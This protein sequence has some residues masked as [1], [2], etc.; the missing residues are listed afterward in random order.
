[1]T[2]FTDY[3]L[4]IWLTGDQVY[5]GVICRYGSIKHLLEPGD[6]VRKALHFEV[7]KYIKAN[8]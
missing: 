4:I 6:Y 2:Q 1:M 5:G 7:Q 3:D 8:F